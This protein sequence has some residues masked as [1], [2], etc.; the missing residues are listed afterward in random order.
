[1][2]GRATFRV[3]PKEGVDLG[4]WGAIR[5]VRLVALFAAV[6]AVGILVRSLGMFG[7]DA[8]PRLPGIAVWVVPVLALAE[9]R[10]LLRTLH[11]LGRRHQRR[12]DHRFPEAIPATVTTS[13]DEPVDAIV[14]DASPTGAA[15]VLRDHVPIGGL[16]RLDASLAQAA[17][18]RVPFSATYEVR[19]TR[20]DGELWR[21]GARIVDVAPDDLDH[22]VELCHVVSP[23]ERLRGLCLVALPARDAASEDA[24]AG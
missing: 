18:R 19:S 3:T 1:V 10:R 9:L 13:D 16:F 17:G 15:I 6:L 4:G 5:Q 22:L 14:V 21:V 7:L 2:P 12:F 11:L 8:L 23:Y 20:F 24:T